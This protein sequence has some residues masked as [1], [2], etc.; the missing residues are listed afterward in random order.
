MPLPRVRGA[1]PAGERGA[2]SLLGPRRLSPP[3]H[4]VAAS[5][6]KRGAG[7]ILR[8]SFLVPLSHGTGKLFL[9][10]GLLPGSLRRRL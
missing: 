4:I 9:A 5:P 7:V 2:S 6:R 8:P 3:P 1:A 10:K